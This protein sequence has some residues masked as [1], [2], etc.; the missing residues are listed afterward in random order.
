MVHTLLCFKLNM[1]CT[2]LVIKIPCTLCYSDKLCETRVSCSRMCNFSNRWPYSATP[3]LKIGNKLNSVLRVIYSYAVTSLPIHLSRESSENRLVAQTSLYIVQTFFGRLVSLPL[4]VL[5]GMLSD[6]SPMSLCFMGLR[7][8]FGK[9]PGALCALL[10]WLCRR[11]RQ[12]SWN[13]NKHD[14]YDQ[15]GKSKNSYKMVGRFPAGING[16]NVKWKELILLLS[17]TIFSSS[18]LLCKFWWSFGSL[19]GRI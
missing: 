2:S 3:F 15:T 7:F 5:I 11:G 9:D 4:E 12:R 1:N 14:S 19:L 13:N 16:R 10:H 18:E 6:G 17:K 8:V